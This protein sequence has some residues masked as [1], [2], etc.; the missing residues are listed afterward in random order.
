LPLITMGFAGL[1]A[2]AIARGIRW[3]VITVAIVVLLLA[4]WILAASILFL[5]DV[6]VALRAVQGVA[7]LGIMKA[8]AKTG[9][10]G[11]LFLVAYSVAGIGA[12]RFAS[13]LKAR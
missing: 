3:Q 7:Q 8:I 10:L 6:P 13:R 12:L 11:T 5:L 9:L 2:S 1:L 4:A